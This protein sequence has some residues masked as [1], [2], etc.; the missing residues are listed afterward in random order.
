MEVTGLVVTQH[1]VVSQNGVPPAASYPSQ[2]DETRAILA[3]I[4]RGEIWICATL[5]EFAGRL[6]P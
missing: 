3:Q 4:R 2:H 1:L 5:G 6:S